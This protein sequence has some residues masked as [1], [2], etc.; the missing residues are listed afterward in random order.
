MG[1]AGTHRAG[2]GRAGLPEGRGSLHVYPCGLGMPSAPSAGANAGTRPGEA[3]EGTRL[4]R[5][6]R[7]CGPAGA[8]EARGAPRKDAALRP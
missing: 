5:G 1:G 2:H 6:R 7:V 4:L 3:G 8:A